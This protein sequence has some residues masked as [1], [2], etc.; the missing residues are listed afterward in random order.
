METD[1]ASI[2]GND[3]IDKEIFLFLWVCLYVC[4]TWERQIVDIYMIVYGLLPLV[5]VDACKTFNIATWF[6]FKLA[7]V[8]LPL[9]LPNYWKPS[10]ILLHHCAMDKDQKNLLH[11]VLR[12][13]WSLQLLED[14]NVIDTCINVQLLK[15]LLDMSLLGRINQNNLAFGCI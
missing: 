11:K 8:M 5:A 2:N 4:F 14:W 12:N 9:P 1:S 6:K 3:P 10:Q 15:F 13:S 7:A